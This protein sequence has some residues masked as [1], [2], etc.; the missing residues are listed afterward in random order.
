MSRISR[1]VCGLI[2]LTAAGASSADVYKQVDADGRLSYSSE[3]TASSILVIATND[4]RNFATPTARP[5]TETSSRATTGSRPKNPMPEALVEGFQA[6]RYRLIAAQEEFAADFQISEMVS[7]H[8]RNFTRYFEKMGA[9]E[10]RLEL[11]MTEYLGALTRYNE[12]LAAQGSSP[13]ADDVSGSG[14]FQ[15]ALTGWRQIQAEVAAMDA[16]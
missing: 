7:G 16:R 5:P 4:S 9:R 12:E 13:V 1:L 8:H 11:A 14:A 10:N 2:L 3:R 15:E 6:S